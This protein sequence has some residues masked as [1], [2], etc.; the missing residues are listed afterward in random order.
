MG[1]NADFKMLKEIQRYS[2]MLNVLTGNISDA[3]LISGSESK[4]SISI[5]LP[6]IYVTV[7]EAGGKMTDCTFKEHVRKKRRKTAG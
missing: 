3:E 1:L 2:V 7:L 5:L 6:L 4:Y